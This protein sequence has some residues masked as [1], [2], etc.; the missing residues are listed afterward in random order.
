MLIGFLSTIIILCNLLFKKNKFLY[1][2]TFFWMWILMAG[3]YGIADENIY[4]SRYN[5]ST[6]WASETEI[7]YYGIILIFNKLGIEFITY[8]IIITFVQLLLIFTTIWKYGAYPNLV[9]ALYFLF[10]FPLNI[11]QMRNALA[12]AI[13]IWGLRYLF[14][15][16]DLVKIK[17]LRLTVSDI[18][19]I[20]VILIASC[21]HT[22]SIGWLIL[23][24]AKKM[25][26]KF[27]IIFVILLN[28]L[29]I[30]V[31]SPQNVLKMINIFGGGNR[32]SA[33]FS[34]AYQL[35]NARQYGNLIG[36]L[37]TAIVV[38]L[39]CI[40]ILY[41]KKNRGVISKAELLIKCNISILF[42]IGIV[43]R[44]TGEIYRLQ[45]GLTIL[46]L[47]MIS[48]LIYSKQFH[49]NKIS[50]NNL[51]VIFA[52]GIYTVGNVWIRYFP[53]LIPTIILPILQNNMFINF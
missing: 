44:Y 6:T 5:L 39:L 50:K 37:F 11:A 20:I 31:L 38:I 40:Y 46:N 17:R 24:I 16:D 42:I 34:E 2:L 52:L 30:F 33:Y 8:K 18:K 48:N 26:I 10:P 15:N 41:S 47:I 49:I 13:F 53:Y 28:I 19:F 43:L 36:I 9:I 23:L 45:E 1:M 35:S 22:A 51:I 25:N 32:I 14:Q 29:I 3:T 7:L 12:T 21:I 4:I 27:N